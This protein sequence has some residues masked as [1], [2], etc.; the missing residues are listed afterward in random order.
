[1]KLH[2][3]TVQVPIVEVLVIPRATRDLIFKAR[4]VMD[5]GPHDEI[6]PEP[7]P[8]VI[9]RPNQAPV[10]NREDKKFQKKFS[11]WH[12]QR[13]AWMVLE[14]LKATDGLEFETV[15]STKPETW[16]NWR[17]EMFDAGL[18]PVEVNKIE[19]LVV[20]ACRLDQSKIDKATESFLAEQAR[21]QSQGSSQS[22]EHS[23]TPSGELVNV[24]E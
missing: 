24:S 19:A 2:G 8:P 17:Q 23:A 9:Q 6:N 11:K 15:D 13:W 1:M 16:V 22:S 7:K 4:P 14:G 10:P 12:D 3:Q 5:F 21:I 18:V 20:T